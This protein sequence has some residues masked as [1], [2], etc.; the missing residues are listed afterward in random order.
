MR[1]NLAQLQR[2][3][4]TGDPLMH[5]ACQY[6]VRAGQEVCRELPCDPPDLLG[7]E[8][9]QELRPVPFRQHLRSFRRRRRSCGDR[10]RGG[11]CGLEGTIAFSLSDPDLVNH[12]RDHGQG[13]HK[14]HIVE[15]DGGAGSELHPFAHRGGRQQLLHC[16]RVLNGVEER[17]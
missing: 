11:T 13:H 9:G 17:A 16:G 15:L 5:Q 7:L 3:V 14:L 4:R 10:R 1:D 2:G 6:L 8:F 12:V